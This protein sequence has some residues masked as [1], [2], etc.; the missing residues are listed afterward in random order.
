MPVLEKH[1]WFRWVLSH[2]ELAGTV[3]CT[4]SLALEKDFMSWEKHSEAS[5]CPLRRLWA[6]SEVWMLGR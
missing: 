2:H 5:V 4:L 1:A 3:N 6:H